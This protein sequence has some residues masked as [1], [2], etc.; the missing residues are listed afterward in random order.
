MSELVD[1]RIVEMGFDN[2]NFESNV[3]TSMSTLDKLKNSLNF[4]GIS[5]SLNQNLGNV[6]TSV[7]TS[8]LSK[9]SAGF[10]AMEVVAISAIANITNKV[11]DLGL[12]MVKSLSVDNI[13]VG[14]DK[15]AQKSVSVGTL[16]SQGYDMGTVTTQLEKLQWYTD[17]TSYEFTEMVSNISKFTAA[18]Q[19][20][21]E[22][23]QAMMGIANWAALSGQNAGVASRAMYQLSQAIGSGVIRLQ[24]WKSIQTANMD[25]SEFRQRALDAAV[26]AGKL[27]RSIDGTYNTLSG[28]SFNINQFT[29]ELDEGWFTSDVLMSVL[30]NYSSAVDDIYEIIQTD[31]TINLS[32][33]AMEKYGYTMDSFGLKAFKAAQ[34]ARTLKDALNA[35]REA[36][37]SSWTNIFET[38][39][40]NY[41]D[42]K[43]LW[44]DLAN[45]LYGV[46]V[47]GLTKVNSILKSW[48]KLGGR[49]DLF[50]NTEE[51]TGAFWNLFYAIVELK[52][53]V[54]KSWDYIFPWSKMEDESEYIEDVGSKIKKFT[55]K[56]KELSEGL[57]LNEETSEKLGNILKGVFSIFKAVIKSI[58]ALWVGIQPLIY[59]VKDLFSYLFS[60][61]SGYGTKITQFVE[62]TDI[63]SYYGNRMASVLTKIIEKIK[64]LKI[65]DKVLEIF[66]KVKSAIKEV[67][68]SIFNAGSIE[69][70]A[71][72]GVIDINDWKKMNETVKGFS[73]YIN[74]VKNAI[75]K[76]IK[77]IKDF[78][79]IE[80]ASNFIETVKNKLSSLFEIFK[81]NGGTSE[82]FIRILNGLKAAFEILKN[83]FVAVYEAAIKYLVPALKKTFDSILILSS[84][85][86]GNIVKFL[87]YIG[88]LIVRF[89]KFTKSNNSFRKVIDVIANAFKK[90]LDI[91]K[92]VFS[93][94]GK[95]DSSGVDK[96]TD[97]TTEKFNP[98]K[99]ILTG[100]GKLFTGL[101]SVLKAV[102][103]VIGQLLGYIGHVLGFLGDQLSVVFSGEN[104]LLSIEKLLDAAFWA[105]IVVSLYKAVDIFRKIQIAFADIVGGFADVLDSKA[106]LQ[107][108]EALKALS[109]AILLIVVSIVLLAAID[110]DK[111]TAAMASMIVL[112]SA[113]TGMMVIMKKMFT[114]TK[115]LGIKSLVTAYSMR[116]AAAAMQTLAISVAILAASVFLLSSIKEDE[117]I[118]GIMGITMLITLLLGASAIIGKNQKLFAK[119]ASGLI[120]MALAITLLSIPLRK[121][122]SMNPDDFKQGV[123]GITLLTGLVTLFAAVSGQVK[124]ALITSSGMLAFAASLMLMTIPMKIIGGMSWAEIAVAIVGITSMVAML[125][126]M[127]L[128]SKFVS[129]AIITAIGMVIMSKALVIFAGAMLMLSAISWSG[130]AR[131]M[132]TLAAMIGLLLVLEQIV[133]IKMVSAISALGISL[134][135]LSVG[136]MTFAMAMKTLSLV[137]YGDILKTVVALSAIVLTMMIF[138]KSMLKVIPTMIGLGLGLIV[139]SSGLMLFAIAMGTLGMMSWE[140]M[141]KS[142][143]VIVGV[144]VVLGLAAYVLSPL[145][146]VILGLAFS[147]LIFGA[148]AM[149]LAA[150]MTV[151]ITTVGIFGNAIA[152]VLIKIAN[153]IITAA[154]AI[155]QAIVTIIVSLL[156]GLN[157][158][159]P[160]LGTL[161][162]TVIDTILLI[163]QN[164]GPK[165]IDTALKLVTSL[166]ESLANYFPSIVSSLLS[167]LV[168]LLE[169]IR[170]QIAKIVDI[171]IDI[172]MNIL[173]ALQERLPEIIMTVVSVALTIIDALIDA[174]IMAVPRLVSAAFDLLL[175][176]VDGLGQALEDNTER[177]RETMI[178]FAGHMWNAFKN[179]WGINSPS[180]KMAEAA[181]FL[182][183]GIV[184]GLWNGISYLLTTIGQWA[185]QVISALTSIATKGLEIGKNI[186]MNILN[187]VKSGWNA[188]SSWFGTTASSIGNFFKDTYGSLVKT[189]SGIIS[190]IGEGLKTGWNTVSSWFNKTASSI[191]G[192]FSSGW[193]TMSDVGTNLMSG[194]KD[195]L[196]NSWESVKNTVTDVGTKVTDWFKSIFGIHSPSRVF[197]EIGKFVD[198]GFAKGIK[199]NSVEV[200]DA[201]EKLGDNTINEVE[202]SGISGAIEKVMKL[203][204]S[205]IGNEIVIRPVM[206][207]T[208]IQ[209]GTDLMIAMMGRANGY[210]VS[211]NSRMAESTYTSMSRSSNQQVSSK[212]NRND[213]SNSNMQGEQSTINNTFNI[214]GNNPKEIADEVS[215]VIQKQ[216][217]R[218]HATWAQ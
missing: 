16:I 19:G 90:L 96:F 152:N 3:K 93:E 214:T 85:A 4:S 60:L 167:M 102:V 153:G 67:I 100:L 195:G 166:L 52:D 201:M 70:I 1:E 140:S 142:L 104:S 178:K 101:W 91:I 33:E 127:S 103:P 108:A 81:A 71:L 72:G 95:V 139:L 136:L 61:F 189:G 185:S 66:R 28:K 106:M 94:F 76:F 92:R 12:N 89:N 144:F 105:V 11:V 43:V 191:G 172:L 131:S 213:I 39:F 145:I 155:V 209:N 188:V 115:G 38:I 161:V 88:D 97:T 62:T 216:I 18:G 207:L 208:E 154:P 69:P 128:A 54:K 186:A 169:G 40:G 99:E 206:D 35:T 158:I 148:A 163:L 137:K 215:K 44:T 30:G 180:T 179:F 56:L 63:F 42:A 58:E 133:T 196:V 193:N 181:K 198:L 174:I 197:A 175:G 2:R 9:A 170:N 199:D 183:D 182:I 73:Y 41:E 6:D 55:E 59:V 26:A 86:G 134:S 126:A 31:D 75:V 29:T 151:V 5:R 113:L 129:K 149:L 20:L 22:S 17:E 25:T 217:G 192:F 124:K 203:I 14:W 132:T 7:L 109:V 168:S 122:G 107:Y 156:D 10:T 65:L 80:K 32:S 36:V 77:V 114:E 78:N 46:F 200:E 117:M 202:K 47:E 27:T 135:V 21:E 51:E 23:V 15:Y 218:R 118:R 184:N 146:P 123:F 48:S 49:S 119:G 125:L 116:T 187:G 37:G 84:K 176:L 157:A 194:L 164:Q 87:A 79:V 45:E 204:D 212:Q 171:V 98:L 159:I 147:M 141:G 143:L 50:A 34:E 53:L 177:V 110:N 210:S 165:I 83:V 112:L 64:E 160:A 211:G 162:I 111:L 138:S 205:G 68:D 8:G 120:T 24:D 150:A 130:I 190:K 82:N 57:Y 74:V 13:M 173:T 121:I